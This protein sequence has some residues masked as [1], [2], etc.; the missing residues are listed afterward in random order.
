MPPVGAAI[1]AIGSA[2]GGAVS[3]VSAF[4]AGSFLGSILV[5][6]A[7]SLGLSLVARALAPKPKINQRGIQTAVTTTGGTTPQAFI[8]GRTATAGHHVCPPMSHDDGKTPNGYLTYVIELSDI[9]GIALSRLILND[10]YSALDGTSTHPDYGTPLPGQRLGSTDHAWIRF[11]NGTQTAADPMLVARYASAPDRPWSSS[12]IGQ[13]TAYAVLTFRYNREIYTSLPQ[14]RFEL[15]GIALYDPRFDSSVGGSGPQRWTQPASWTRPANPAVMIY[16]ILRGIQLPSG[17]IW[18]GDVPA[19]DLPLDNWVAAMNAC[20]APIGGRPSFEAGLEVK[21]EMEPAEVIEELAKTCLGQISEMGGV[22]RLRVGAPAAPVQFITDEDI[23]ISA[24]RELEPFPGLAASTNAIFSD[25]PEPESLWLPRA[26]PPLLNPAWEA[27]DGG[28][29]LA[30][31]LNFPAC[32][33][34]SQV[35]QLMAAYAQDARRFRVHRLV[36]PPE[37]FLLEPLD[38]IAWSS[39][40]NGYMAKIFEVVE[41]LDQPGSINQELLLRERDPGDYSWSA[42]DDLPG[43]LP[44]TGLAPRPPQIIEGWSATATTLKDGAGLPRRPAIQLT[45]LGTA[46]ADAVLVRYEIRLAD[47][48][49]TVVTGLADRAAG[50][51]LVCEGLLPETAYQVRG[52]YVADRPTDWSSW[53]DVTTPAIYLAMADLDAALRDIIATARDDALEANTRLDAINSVIDAEILNALDASGAIRTEILAAKAALKGEIEAPGSL[54]STR[55]ATLGESIGSLQATLSA[56]Y[57]T[58]TATD[59]AIAGALTSFETSF[60]ADIQ[61][62]LETLYYTRAQTDSALSATST[63]LQSGITTVQGLAESKGKVFTQTTAP[64]ASERLPQNL[65]IDTTDGLNIP[66]HWTGSAWSALSDKTPETRAVATL[67]ATLTNSYYTRVQTDSAIATS[68]QTVQANLNAVQAQ[69]SVNATALANLNG[70]SARFQALTTVD[71]GLQAAGIEAVSWNTSGQGSGSAVRLLGDDVI[72]PGSLS[73]SSLTVTDLAGTLIPNGAFRFADLRGWSAVHSSYQLLARNTASAIT[74]IATAPTGHVLANLTDGTARFA[75]LETGISVKPGERFTASMA[76][77][78]SGSGANIR[79][80][81]QF[82][83]RNADGALLTTLSRSFATTSQNWIT[84]EADPVTAPSQAARLDIRLS[85]SGGGSF[86]G[87]AYS[88]NIEVLRQRD[89]ATLITPASITTAQINA[90][91]FASAGLSVFGG[92]LQSSNFVS[93]ASGTGWRIQNTGAAEFGTLALRENAVTAIRA[94]SLGGSLSSTNGTWTNLLSLTF[95]PAGDDLVVWISGL[96]RASG[97]GSSENWVDSLLQTRL[98]WRGLQVPNSLRTAGRS[99]YLSASE[100]NFADSVLI[101]AS[102]TSPGTLILQ[103][104]RNDPTGIIFVSTGLY[105]PVLICGEFKR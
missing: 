5:N 80:Q 46:A 49:Q 43:V 1:A 67:T 66:K 65:W 96:A 74:A 20:D 22:F 44:V 24:P 61:A 72:V 21:L 36:L 25:Y 41:I 88:T 45:W 32:S 62:R 10:G 8:L 60:G 31:S 18:G 53:L 9:P 90:L 56:E 54:L 63:S 76:L 69:V 83:F 101:T 11:Y 84:F 93:G 50:S 94:A 92:S 57:Y 98:L 104:R 103:T 6:T 28:R 78:A 81:I 3:A 15:D 59:L 34:I 73:A 47:S 7:V 48:A 35:A 19:E 77:A 14:V 102:G 70:A 13:G 91:S 2:I 85:R 30:T 16:N 26:A 37:A 87:T 58:I 23:V 55:I 33:N 38:T 29:R 97:N 42:S 105:D 27:E 40:R 79:W 100:A 51:V 64:P 12:F 68:Q 4:A 95:T 89:G 75:T 82:L 17:D 52:R 71:G 99:T 86:T 39:A